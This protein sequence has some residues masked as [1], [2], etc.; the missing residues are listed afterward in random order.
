MDIVV[1]SGTANVGRGIPSLGTGD[2]GG[3]A[4]LGTGDCVGD[5]VSLGTGGVAS[6][7]TGDCVGDCVSSGTGDCV[8]D[9]VSLGTG[10][11]ASLGELYEVAVSPSL[12]MNI[13]IYIYIYYLYIKNRNIVFNQTYLIIKGMPPDIVARGS[14]DSMSPILTRVARGS[15]TVCPRY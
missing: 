9:C 3:V 10:G 14:G 1:I 13:Y 5:C 7:G 11:V 4:S 2:T 6:L 8:G 15:G 12:D